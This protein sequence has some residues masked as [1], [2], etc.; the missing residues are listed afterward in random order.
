MQPKKD[1]TEPF[2]WRSG[3]LRKHCCAA[4]VCV[5][6]NLVAIK[7]SRK[8]LRDS[9][10]QIAKARRNGE[11]VCRTHFVQ[12]VTF[13]RHCLWLCPLKE[14]SDVQ[15]ESSVFRQ[16]SFN[17][18]SERASGMG[19][20]RQSRDRCTRSMRRGSPLRF[21]LR[22]GLQQH[23]AEVVLSFLWRSR[24]NFPP[25]DFVRDVLG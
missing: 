17:V 11:E 5:V 22:S 21:V 7:E 10:S 16:G 12:T 20:A 2:S 18:P 6:N 8:V 19:F 9:R 3:R 23:T 1:T 4:A 13:R 15:S 24:E 14:L 25:S